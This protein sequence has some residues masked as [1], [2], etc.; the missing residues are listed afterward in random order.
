M[1]VAIGIN[2]VELHQAQQGYNNNRN[3]IM[4]LSACIKLCTSRAH[5]LEEFGFVLVESEAAV[6][7]RCAGPQGGE[8]SAEH[9]PVYLPSS[10]SPINLPPPA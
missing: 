5:L 3:I 7:E 4:E 8:D 10:F 2:A 1:S 6:L 9:P